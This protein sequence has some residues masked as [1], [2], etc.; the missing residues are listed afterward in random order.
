VSDAEL[1]RRILEA[2]ESNSPAVLVTVIGTSG[3]TPSAL[4]SRLLV[5]P[6]GS[7]CGTIGGGDIEHQA[8]ARARTGIQA[9]VRER[10]DLGSLPDRGSVP[11]SMICG[12][13]VELLFE[14]LGNA[15]RLYLVGGGHCAVE[16][17]PIAARLGFH[18]TVI[19]N[20]PEWASR[21]KH[22]AAARLA[23]APYSEVASHISFGPDAWVVIM[24]HGHEHDELVLR[25]CLRRELRYLGMIGSRRKVTQCFERLLADGFDRAEL[26]RVFAPIGFGV[27][28]ET[29]AEIAVSIAAQLAAVR[30]GVDRF[31]FNSNP[32][33]EDARA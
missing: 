21:E 19:D 2:V 6:D 24:T 4:G 27:G 28:S 32:L 22:P 15:P 9:P 13:T 30:A 31:P 11:T 17:S 16:L 33:L 8:V 5:Y 14:P 7:T 26:A 20:R 18:V 1:H 25:A 12:G 29:P 23:T 3:P 10:F